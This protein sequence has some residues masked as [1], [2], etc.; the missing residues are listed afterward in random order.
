MRRLLRAR[1]R[2]RP[3]DGGYVA[4]M[5]A[6]L[7]TVFMAMAALTVDVGHWYMVGAQAQKAADAAALAGAPN[8]PGKPSEAFATAQDLSRRNGFAN[9]AQATVVTTAVDSQPTRLRV[10]VDREVDN[11]FGSL[12]GI[13]TSTVRR[14]AV[15][16]Y[17]G[18][19]PMGSPCN[20][21]GNDPDATGIRSSN[22]DGAGQFWANVGSP[23]ATKVSGDAFQNNACGSGVDGCVGSTN[24]DYDS[25]GYYYVVTLRRPVSNLRFEAFDPAFVAVGDLC[26]NAALKG[27]DR[28]G[29]TDSR[30]AKGAQS[31]YCTGDQ[32]FG[33]GTGEVA[34]AFTVRQPTAKTTYWDPATYAPVC[35]QTYP[36]HNLTD[37]AKMPTATYDV[38]RRWTQLCT[39]PYAPAG[40][41]MIQVRTNGVGADRA[42][43]HNRFGLRVYSPTD[44]AAKDE[45][46][47]AG[48][49]KMAIYANLPA[50]TTTFHLARVP[51]AAAGQAL[52]VELF[53]IGDSTG[54]GNVSVLAPDGSGLTQ[55][56]GTGPAKGA[57]PTCTIRAS[58]SFNGK[59]QTISVPVPKDY[60][61]Q[62]DDPNSCWF[63]LRY[64]YGS[65]NQPSDTT[66]WK[67]SLAAN[68]VRLVE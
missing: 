52:N 9:G 48:F 23:S 7:M 12:F 62:D 5:V 15:A 17:V 24:V 8:L 22:C 36:G 33:G 10:T 35:T 13:P 20:E 29:K 55:C 65:G 19:L 61:C 41:Y 16:D 42:A 1:L 6:L 26:D 58:S 49:S 57:L 40:Q 32:R 51:S 34:T 37:I 43:G 31:P 11:F 47:I 28:A 63:R 60:S 3:R 18:P 66:S 54:S 44:S 46:S 2:Q 30:Y 45:M 27:R 59:W 4:V 39:I 53:D 21:F 38:F 64:A 14:T 56:T 50:A 68:P 25:Q 67:A